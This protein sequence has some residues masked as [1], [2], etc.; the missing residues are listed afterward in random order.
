M[1]PLD[2]SLSVSVDMEDLTCSSPPAPP[3]ITPPSSPNVQMRESPWEPL[4]LQLDYWQPLPKFIEKTDKLKQDGKTSLKGL[5]RGLQ[6]T[7]SAGSLNVTV[8]MA[9]KEKKQKSE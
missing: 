6:V 8:H 1:G 9:N 3:S 2:N 4:E 7:P 5:F